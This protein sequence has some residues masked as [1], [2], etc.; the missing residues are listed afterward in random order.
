V[1]RHLGP[2]DPRRIA[3]EQLATR[4]GNEKWQKVDG[5]HVLAALHAANSKARREERQ[6][7]SFRNTL[8]ASAVALSIAAV[9]IAIVGWRA[10]SSIPLCFHPSPIGR[11][12]DQ[13]GRAQYQTARRDAR[14]SADRRRHA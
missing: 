1:R 9:A 3:V 2:E 8:I 11:L 10:P 6:L 13:R 4:A 5:E 7:R 14:P 12:S